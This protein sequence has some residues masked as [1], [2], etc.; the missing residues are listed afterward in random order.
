MFK[1]I[2]I[3]E[4]IDSIQNS[5]I[6]LVKELT[7]AEVQHSKYCD[8]AYLK[9]K[10]AKLDQAP[11]DLLITD[12][13][14]VQDHRDILLK[15]GEDLIKVVKEV[16]SDIKIIAYSIEDKSYKIKQLFDNFGINGF[17]SKG[18]NGSAEL[19]KAIVALAENDESYIDSKLEHAFKTSKIIEIEDYDLQLL[20]YLSMGFSQAEIGELFKKNNIAPSGSSAIEKRINK[21]KIYF[22]AKNTIHLISATKDLGLI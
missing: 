7:D 5:V 16:Q 14:F 9:I 20:K 10:K 4:D 18:R 3:V 12:L 11:F 6:S 2:L 15:S 17:V 8:E 22:K 21:L 13:S 19:E 1:K